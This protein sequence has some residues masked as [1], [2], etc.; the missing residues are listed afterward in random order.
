MTVYM[1]VF[2]CLSLVLEVFLC[3]FDFLIG[4]S[5]VLEDFICRFRLSHWAEQNIYSKAD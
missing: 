2:F 3:R 4:L 1:D 5:L